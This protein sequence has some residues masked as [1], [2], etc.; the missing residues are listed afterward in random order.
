MNR[1]KIIY[2]RRKVIAMAAC[3]LAAALMFWVVNHPA[4]VGASASTR[5]LPIYCGQ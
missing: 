1:T 2:L 4:V 5:Q 3:A